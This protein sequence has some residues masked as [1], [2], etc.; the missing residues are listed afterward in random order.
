MITKHHHTKKAPLNGAFIKLIVSR[1]GCKGTYYFHNS[2][3]ENPIFYFLNSITRKFCNFFSP[4]S[5]FNI[6]LT[7]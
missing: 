4:I 5:N 1:R 3:R 7:L 6:V 2:Y